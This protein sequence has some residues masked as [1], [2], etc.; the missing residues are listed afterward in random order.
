M[1]W[2]FHRKTKNVYDVP[3]DGGACGHRRVQR[4]VRPNDFVDGCG[5]CGARRTGTERS[6]GGHERHAV[7][8]IDR[9][10]SSEN[11]HRD[12]ASKLLVSPR[13]SLSIYM[14]CVLRRRVPYSRVGQKRADRETEQM[15]DLFA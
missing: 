3:A 12:S 9:L 2:V 14:P 1:M 10:E 13:D 15:R 8:R 4:V 7:F 5:G 11:I 6:S